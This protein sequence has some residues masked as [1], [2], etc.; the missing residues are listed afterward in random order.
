AL[1]LL[2]GPVGL[3]VLWGRRWRMLAGAVIGGAVLW[4]LA[5]PQYLPEYVIKIAPVLAAGTGLFENPS[6]GGTVIRLLDPATFTGRAR[7][8]PAAARVI[9]LLIALAVLAVTFV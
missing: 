7:D 6:P 4:L 9:T 3:L 2:Q 8:T 1:K 5:V